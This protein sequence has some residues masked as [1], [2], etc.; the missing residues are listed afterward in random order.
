MK[1][2]QLI[3][4][5]QISSNIYVSLKK[6]YR[7]LTNFGI[8]HCYH[9]SS[10]NWNGEHRVLKTKPFDCAWIYFSKEKGIRVSIVQLKQ[11]DSNLCNIVNMGCQ[12][13]LWYFLKMWPLV[14]RSTDLETSY[15]AL[16][17][18]AVRHR[19]PIMHIQVNVQLVQSDTQACKQVYI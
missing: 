5:G 2:I 16:I 3:T 13:F 17:I 18:Q 12:L 6:I 9:R 1:L 10:V 7:K 11:L 14:P 19:S 15:S 8:P 4:F